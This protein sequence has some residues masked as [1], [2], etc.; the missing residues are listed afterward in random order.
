L[1]LD[2]ERSFGTLKI[3]GGTALKTSEL[4][5]STIRKC[6]LPAWHTRSAVP[7]G[8]VASEPMRIQIAG[9]YGQL[10]SQGILLV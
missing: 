9:P 1:L 3:D 4:D 5:L 6:R 10:A 2:A 8:R 7:L